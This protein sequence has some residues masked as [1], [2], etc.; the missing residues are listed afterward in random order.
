MRIVKGEHQIADTDGESGFPRFQSST[1]ISWATVVSMQFMMSATLWKP[2]IGALATAPPTALSPH[3]EHTGDF[4]RHLRRRSVA[5]SLISSLLRNE[6]SLGRLINQGRCL[7]IAELAQDEGD[8]LRMFGLKKSC[9]F[10]GSARCSDFHGFKLAG[11]GQ[12]L[13]DAPRHRFRQRP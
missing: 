11:L 4:L 6:I 1:R 7:T 10:C 13:H 3:G 12:P 8:V 2:R 5:G 9:S